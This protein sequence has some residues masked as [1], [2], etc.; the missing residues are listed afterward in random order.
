LLLVLLLWGI[1]IFL[2]LGSTQDAISKAGIVRDEALRE[3][4]VDKIRKFVT[5][6]CGKE[7]RGLMPS[8]ITGMDGNHEF[9]AWIG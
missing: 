8:P 7:W 9:L 2:F 4:A 3:K 1:G 5:E 6:D